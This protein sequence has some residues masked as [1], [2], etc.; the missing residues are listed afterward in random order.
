MKIKAQLGMVM[1]LDKCLGCHT[2]SIPCKNVWTNRTGAE[3]I[4]YNNVETKPGIGYPKRWENQDQWEGGWTLG[5]KGLALRSGGAAKK[6]AKIFH[7][8]D[9]PRIDDYYEP[10]SYDYEKLTGSPELKH[11]P[12]ARPKSLITGENMRVQWGPN[13]EDDLA[14]ANVTGLDDVNFAGLEKEIYLQFKNVFMLYLPRICEHCL[15]PACVASCPSGALY[16]RDEDGIVLVDQERCRG[17]RFCVSGCPYKK[18]YYNW[19]TGR[20]EKC[21]FCYPRIEAGLP[22]LC[23]ESCVGRIRYI[24]VMLYDAERVP[25]AAAAARDGDLYSAQTDLFLDANDPAVA[26]AA[27]TAGIAAHMIDAAKN[28]PVYKLAVEWRLAL[29]PHPEFRTLPMVWYIPP[30]SPLVNLSEKVGAAGIIDR[31]RIP[32]KYLANLL[33]AGDEAPV[34]L[35][36]KRLMALRTYM[37]SKQ[38]AKSPDAAVLED[39]GL[40]PDEAEKMYRLLAIAKYGER[41]VIPTAQR[42]GVENLHRE[43]GQCGFPPQSQGRKDE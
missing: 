32:I 18:V 41:F 20:S 10:W 26:S 39:A 40:S 7:N 19:K 23:A 15:N 2:C 1:N 24:G 27:A 4:W 21:L 14:G 42:E 5:K 36:L 33:A 16:K 8:P 11:Q 34:R 38:L 29:P 9:L 3:Y 28:S 13:W 43:R 17:W 31:L 30:L 6:L 12:S 35:A 22:T 37:R 25:A